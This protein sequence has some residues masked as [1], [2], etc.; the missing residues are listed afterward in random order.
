M[1]TDTLY[2]FTD[3][4]TV[5]ILIW[6]CINNIYPGINDINVNSLTTNIRVDLLSI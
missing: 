1:R 4:T 6:L 3:R 2:L 5:N